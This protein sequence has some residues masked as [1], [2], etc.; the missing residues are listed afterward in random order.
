MIPK[1]IHFCWFSHSPY[2]TKVVKCM[3]SWQKFLPDYEIVHWDYQKAFATGIPWVIEALSQKNWAFASD[4]VRLYA[5]YTEGG[6]YLD[7]DVEV[8]KSFDDLLDR[9]YIFGYENGSKRIEAAVMGAEPKSELIKEA[10]D[11][12]MNTHFEYDE[13]KVDEMVLPNVLSKAFDNFM[14]LD[15]MP[16][17][18]FSP[19]SFIDGSISTADDTYSIHH[20]HSDWRPES[21]RKG[22]NRRQYLFSK[23]PRPIA[24][25]LALPLSLWTNLTTLGFKGSIRKMFK[26]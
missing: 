13:E 8:L 22:I 14:S 1:K 2:S 10:L 15:I 26:K 9:P 5:L 4:A 12:Y 19:K 11:F 25:L 21:V 6:I 18:V 23:F 3:E 24:E 20:F 7:A 17:W 16:E